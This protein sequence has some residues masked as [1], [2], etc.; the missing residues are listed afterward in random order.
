[1]MIGLANLAISTP[2][3]ARRPLL[4]AAT[5]RPPVIRP[6]R[7]YWATLSPDRHSAYLLPAVNW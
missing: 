6:V 3:L 1:M 4:A 2:S 7:P 5:T